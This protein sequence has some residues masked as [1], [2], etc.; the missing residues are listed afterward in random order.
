MN[1]FASFFRLGSAVAL[2]SIL[3]LASRAQLI[4]NG[5]F[6]SAID[7]DGWTFDLVN[8]SGDFATVTTLDPHSGNRAGEFGAVNEQNILAQTVVSTIPGATYSL[9]FWLRNTENGSDESP[10]LFVLKWGTEE[11]VNLSN[12]PAFDY[13][14]YTYELT[15]QTS[16]TVLQ[17]GFQNN[18]GYWRLDDVS[19]TQRSAPVPDDATTFV[20]LAVGLVGL[21]VMR[22]NRN[23]SW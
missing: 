2:I 23:P 1:M 12:E 3:T 14:Q 4:T 20:L 18:P 13:R 7:F 8:G 21:S 9:D 22:R 5:G 15:A 10:N 6:E 16:S 19:L 17:F 11:I